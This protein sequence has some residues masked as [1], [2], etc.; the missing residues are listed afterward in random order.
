MNSNI[1]NGYDENGVRGGVGHWV[2]EVSEIDET[3]LG[4]FDEYDFLKE[5]DKGHFVECAKCG[6]MVLAK[7]TIKTH[8]GTGFLCEKCMKEFD[9]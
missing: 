8:Y 5:V 2:D 9:I 3:E 7:N 4:K 6:K 1:P